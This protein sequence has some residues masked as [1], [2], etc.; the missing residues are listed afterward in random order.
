MATKPPTK[1]VAKARVDLIDALVSQVAP[2]LVHGSHSQE[3]KLTIKR[4]VQITMAP[5]DFEL[6]ESIKKAYKMSRPELI[7]RILW[8]LCRAIRTGRDPWT[9][10]VINWDSGVTRIPRFLRD[11]LGLD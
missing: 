1:K 11:H 2:C 6:F 4:S 7:N 8:L 9:G 5:A 10:E 3:P